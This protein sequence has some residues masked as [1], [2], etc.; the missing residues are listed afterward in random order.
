MQL[1]NT[2]VFGATLIA[3]TVAQTPTTTSLHFTSIPTALVA[4]VKQTIGW[5]GGNGNGVNIILQQGPADNL[6][7][8]PIPPIASGQEG[9]STTWVPPKSLPDAGNYALRI[10]QGE[11]SV[12]YSGM[13]QLFQGCSTCPTDAAAALAT[14]SKTSTGS[15]TV[16]S[17]S[18]TASS[19]SK[20]SVGAP[21]VAPGS[22]SSSNSTG[23]T[24]LSGNSTTT[25]SSTNSTLGTGGS[26]SNMTMSVTNSTTNSTTNSAKL[27]ATSSK[28]TSPSSTSSSSSSSSSSQS[29]SS[30]TGSSNSPTPTKSNG[31]TVAA[32][33]FAL[34]LCAIVGIIYLG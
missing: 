7:D 29:T 34:V 32:S 15:A 18:S 27:H 33:N 16:S 28:P 9:N 30:S 10:E 24:G 26:M 17:P 20:S 23:A 19:A 12:N 11:D 4:G 21:I 25:G 1:F 22:K 6:K 8:V 2:L 14:T 5:A 31:V 13:L 3:A